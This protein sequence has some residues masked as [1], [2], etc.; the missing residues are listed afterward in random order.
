MNEQNNEL[1]E[2][3]ITL[4]NDSKKVDEGINESLN[5]GYEDG[6]ASIN[7]EGDS[8]K[9]KMKQVKSKA[10]N[11]EQNLLAYA[12]KGNRIDLNKIRKDVLFDLVIELILEI[13]KVQNAVLTQEEESKTVYGEYSKEKKVSTNIRKKFEFLGRKLSPTYRE[14]TIASIGVDFNED[15]IIDMIIRDNLNKQ[16]ETQQ[17]ILTLRTKVAQSAQLLADLRKQQ[18]KIVCSSNNMTDKIIQNKEIDIKETMEDLLGKTGIEQPSIKQAEFKELTENLTE[19]NAV[20]LSCVNFDDVKQKI[21]T[22]ELQLLSILGEQGV[23]LY[24]EIET[25]MLE[26]G[27]SSSKCE[28]ILNTLKGLSVV[29]VQTN[30][31]TMQRRSGVR[32]ITLNKSVGIPIF[33]DLFSKKPVKSESQSIIEQHDNLQHGYS[34]KECCSILTEL[35]YGEVSMD[36]KANTIDLGNNKKWIPDIIAIDP[37]SQKRVYFEVEYGNHTSE[38]FEEKLTKANTKTNI[39]RFIVPSTLTKDKL[40]RKVETWK[41]KKSANRATSILISIGTFEEVKSKSWGVEYK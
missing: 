1:L 40:I 8:K 12:I 32:V 29:D 16:K 20:G 2:S 10:T 39:L 11:E 38:D 15:Q 34:I 14:K 17:E 23:S 28:V 24:P 35:G 19:G 18:E 3:L 4:T 37:V 30:L 22:G 26:C 36:R 21:K 7:N 6:E 27:Y 25:K 13:R 41:A 33:I 9:K 5:E 31:K